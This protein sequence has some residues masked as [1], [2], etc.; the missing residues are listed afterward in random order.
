[1][2]VAILNLTTPFPE[3][4]HV[5][6]AGHLIRDWLEPAMPEA[7]LRVMDVAQGARLPK[8]DDFDGLVLSGSELGVYDEAL[9]M[10]PLRKTMLA[11]RD[12]G[13]SMLGICFGHQLMADTFGGKAEKASIGT[14]VGVRDFIQDG[15]S[16]PAYA[17]HQ[18]QVIAVPPSAHVV[19]EAA[20]CP[21]GALEY[22]FPA[23]SVQYHPE[24]TGD[25]M[26]L[27]VELASRRYLD[28]TLAEEALAS[29]RSRPVDRSLAVA[30]SAEVLRRFRALV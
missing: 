24:Y 4:A 19:A 17:W 23:Y 6:T 15:R 10:Q 29:I 22:D 2:R 14:V 20:H 7:V 1:M 16:D 26:S 5:T 28:Q 12:A 21:I 25:F 3:L 8:L 11:A 18:D 9:W 13:K 27:E 30:K